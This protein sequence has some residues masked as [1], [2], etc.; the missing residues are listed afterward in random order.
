MFESNARNPKNNVLNRRKILLGF[1]FI[2]AIVMGLSV[3]SIYQL[4]RITDGFNMLYRHPFA[5]SNAAKSVNYY[6]VLMHSNM[7]DV[8]QAQSIID[9][10]IAIDEIAIHEGLAFKQYDILFDRFLGDREQIEQSYQLFLQWRPI[11]SEI[12]SLLRQGGA[13]EA[14]ASVL[15][16]EREYL[17]KLTEN[18]VAL[19]EFAFDKAAEFHFKSLQIKDQ[20]VLV[21]TA[22][23]VLAL[24]L[25]LLLMTELW[26]T[27][28][29]TD[30]ERARRQRLIDEHILMAH[31]DL[32]GRV[33]DASNALCRFFGCWKEELVGN[34]NRFF[35]DDSQESK[36]L[37]QGIFKLLKQGKQWQG[38][39]SYTN[40]QGHT[41]W[42]ESS[43]IPNYSERYEL[44]GYTNILQDI[45]NKKLAHVD[46]LTG[47]LNRRSYDDILPTQISMAQR[48]GYSLTLAVLDIDYFKAFNDLYGHPAGDIALRSLSDVLLN[49]LHR[50]NDF[51]FRIG[52]EEFAI[53]FC[54][55]NIEKTQQFLHSIRTKVQ[56][57]KVENENSQV[58]R[59]LTIS[60]GAVTLL[61]SDILCDEHAFYEAADKALYEAK[62]E[63]NNLVVTA[64]RPKR[65]ALH[66]RSQG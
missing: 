55:S 64:F 50:P 53:L 21:V 49:S 25:I 51:V 11:R 15:Q 46:K 44:I 65:I 32:D 42:A 26:R 6:F 30:K 47:L 5:V 63:R 36:L 9:R 27:I 14:L 13:E 12:I 54:G 34:K 37:E 43:L 66:P 58:S 35:L 41:V 60:I 61:D 20:I 59:Y 19:Q 48:A 45:T 62:I 57:M 22:L 16:Q 8:V 40:V 3:S 56:D 29:I 28:A 2:V 10:E 17:D 23:S 38:E 39:I 24:A 52:G 7:K 31:L 4:S 33:V 18:V 1:S